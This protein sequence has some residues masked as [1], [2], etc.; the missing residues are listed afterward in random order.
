MD[1]LARIDALI[2]KHSLL[3]HP[4]YT[5]WVEGTLPIEAIQ[6]YAKSY[7]QFESSFPRFLS[8]IHSRAEDAQVRQVLLDNLWDE[9]A[10]DENHV[11]LWLRFAEA[12]GLEREEIQDGKPSPAA[13][14]L[15][16]TYRR[17]TENGVAAGLAAIYAY[18]A[19]VPAIAQAKIR[20]LKDHYEVTD[21]YSIAFWHVHES[22][23]V[24]HAQ[25]ERQMLATVAEA[26]PEA[27]VAATEQALEAWWGLLTEADSVIAA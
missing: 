12:L 8:A 24:Q 18:E 6:A 19:Q 13:D 16:Q 15:V 27:A 23:D 25:G 20:G 26:D 4:F 2:Q 3:D 21:D 1:V 5:K 17:A 9:E 11:E 14:E 22:L 7:Y 10:G